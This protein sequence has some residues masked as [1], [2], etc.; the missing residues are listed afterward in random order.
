MLL[1]SILALSPTA[2][3]H[4]NGHG[5]A[6]G[7]SKHHRPAQ[8][9]T[10][11]LVV[12]NPSG[13]LV[14][15]YVDGA[16][17]GVLEHGSMRMVVNTGSHRVKLVHNGRVLE[18]RSVQVYRNE[19]STVRVKTP[20]LGHIQVTNHEGYAVRV[21]VDGR[22]VA[23]LAPGESRSVQ[24]E[25][26]SHRVDMV[27][28]RGHGGTLVTASLHIDGWDYAVLATPQAQAHHSGHQRPR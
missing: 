25:I 23:V 7:H 14:Q 11:S 20:S 3:A 24:V 16:Y 4:G 17:Q 2:Q 27:D 1:L 19:A 8:A 26:G 15:V 13:R 18:N 22:D 28:M 21:Y 5:H 10:G 6:H 9:A 12:N